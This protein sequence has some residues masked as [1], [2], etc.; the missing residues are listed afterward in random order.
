MR[1][2]FVFFEG[3]GKLRHTRLSIFF[4]KRKPVNILFLNG[5]KSALNTEIGIFPT[6][7][8]KA[9]VVNTGLYQFVR[10]NVAANHKQISLSQNDVMC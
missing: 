5:F 6:I 8:L 1:F 10:R 7:W 2:Q 9:T 4:I 3:D